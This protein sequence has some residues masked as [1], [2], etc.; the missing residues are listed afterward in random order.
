MNFNVDDCVEFYNFHINSA[1]PTSYGKNYEFYIREAL[2][3]TAPRASHSDSRCARLRSDLYAVASSSMP[4]SSSASTRFIEGQQ[5][6]GHMLQPYVLC[7]SNICCICCNDYTR[8]LQ[9]YNS[10]VSVISNVC[11]KCFTQ[12]LHMLH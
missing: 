1:H 11:C 9:V 3:S 8:M 2:R 6:D 7:V 4:A 10:N 5:V 12:T